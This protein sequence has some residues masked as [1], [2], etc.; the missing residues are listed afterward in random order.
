VITINKQ[1]GKITHYYDK[2]GVAVITVMNKTLKTGDTIKIS[3][4]DTEFTQKVESI[5]EEHKQLAKVSPG[6]SVGLKVDK[7]VKPGDVIYS[8]PKK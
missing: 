8:V 5:Q 3:G 2:I 1:I 6:A 7:P 4:H